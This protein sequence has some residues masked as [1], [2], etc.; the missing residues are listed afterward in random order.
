MRD[1]GV[2]VLSVGAK[3]GTCDEWGKMGVLVLSG[4][5]KKGALV[6]TGADMGVLDPSRATLVI[7]GGN[8]CSVRDKG[9]LLLSGGQGWHWCQGRYGV[10]VLSGGS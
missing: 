2:L 9:V 5:N 1:D 7:S 8:W 4:A 6:T 10:L 3:G